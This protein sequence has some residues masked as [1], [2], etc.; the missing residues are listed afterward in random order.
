VSTPEWDGGT[1]DGG[2]PYG[3]T[4]YSGAP[5]GGSPYGGTPYAGP[6]QPVWGPP[7]SYGTPGHPP[8][9]APGSPPP[10]WGWTPYPQRPQ[11]PG[12]V[13]AAAVLAFASAVL[14]LMGTLY[15]AAFSALLSL[16]RGPSAGMGPWLVVVQLALVG[17]LVTGGVRV[18]SRDGRW[19]LG[20]AGGQLAL[21]V[22]WLVVLDDVASATIS[23]SVLVLPVVYVVLAGLAGG[24]GFLPDARAWTARPAPAHGAGG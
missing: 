11:R 19:L 1:A 16:A 9:P 22:Y 10:G 2:T 18:L 15:G 17:L 12:S 14:V 3:G 8:Y 24:L 5:Y 6:P 7:P 4:P 13:I 21:S 23:D 20:A